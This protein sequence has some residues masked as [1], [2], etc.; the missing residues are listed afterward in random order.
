M[1]IS[2]R[3]DGC[4]DLTC[5]II[6][7]YS[8]SILNAHQNRN[9]EGTFIILCAC[10]DMHNNNNNNNLIRYGSRLLGMI[11]KTRKVHA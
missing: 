4:L 1:D 10:T 7:L 9:C 6:L 8:V 11:F 3:F 5:D 2:S